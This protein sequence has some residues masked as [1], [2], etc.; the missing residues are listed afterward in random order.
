M[1]HSVKTG[2]I[3]MTQF[4]YTIQD[5]VGL[6]A[7]PAGLLVKEAMKWK[8][9]ITLY[10]K[11]LEEG[12]CEEGKRVDAKRLFAVMGLGIKGGETLVFSIDGED[13]NQASKGLQLFCHENL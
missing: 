8:S 6:H 2:E 9:G 12:K 13:E 3:T 10:K 5:T 1:S 4:E 7:R 11:H